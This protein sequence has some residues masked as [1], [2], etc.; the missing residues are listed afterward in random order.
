MMSV[1]TTFC[2]LYVNDVNE[3]AH[4]CISRVARNTSLLP[5]ALFMTGLLIHTEFFVCRTAL[6]FFSKVCVFPLFKSLYCTFSF[7]VLLLPPIHCRCRGLYLS[8]ITLSDTQT[9]THTHTHILSRT[10][11]GAGSARRKDLCLT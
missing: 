1:L 9:H 5:S 3:V 4:L 6:I 11:L 2:C 8:L 10:P 7:L